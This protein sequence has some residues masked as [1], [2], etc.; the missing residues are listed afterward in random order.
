M[1]ECRIEELICINIYSSGYNSGLFNNM[2]FYEIC[3]LKNINIVYM[4]LF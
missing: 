3:K 2:S 1:N 4:L